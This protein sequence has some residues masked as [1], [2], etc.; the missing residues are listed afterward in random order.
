[1][2]KAIRQIRV[3]GNIA[4]VPLTKG[5]EAV[6][7]AATAQVVH[8]YLA[9]HQPQEGY[10]LHDPRPRP[11]NHAKKR[12]ARPAPAA[13]LGAAPTVRAHMFDPAIADANI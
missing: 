13:L 9:D 5:Y 6:I 12:V 3:E 11:E 10:R 4:Y 7:D 8:G 1:M 2:P